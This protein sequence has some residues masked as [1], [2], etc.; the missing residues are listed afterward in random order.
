MLVVTAPLVWAV[1]AIGW[2]WSFGLVAVFAL[3]G[4]FAVA[5]VAPRDRPAGAEPLAWGAAFR[6][7]GQVAQ[8]PDFWPIF[9]MHAISV[10]VFVTVA[11]LWAGPWLTDVYGYDLAGRGRMLL[12]IAV[13]QIAGVFVVGAID[14]HFRSYRNPVVFFAAAFAVLLLVAAYAPPSRAWLP[15]WLAAF[16]LFISFTPALTAHGRM[17]FPPE[18][19][20]R[21]LTLLNFGVMAGAFFMQLGA[22]LVVQAVAGPVTQGYPPRAYAVLFTILALIIAATLLAYARTADRHPLK[23]SR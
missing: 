5:F 1:E 14:R 3:A 16:G 12:I 10:A 11:G 21:G 7:F 18:T 20:G 13:V 9:A 6:S 23:N 22:G 2:R 19:L 4:A 8:A 17:L 15:V